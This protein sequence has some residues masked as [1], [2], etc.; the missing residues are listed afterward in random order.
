MASNFY[1][2]TNYASFEPF[3]NKIT[4]SLDMLQMVDATDPPIYL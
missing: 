3:R 2:F 4:H 1:G